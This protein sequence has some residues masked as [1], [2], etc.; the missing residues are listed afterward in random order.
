MSL[1]SM[2][3]PAQPAPLSTPLSAPLVGRFR[4]AA[5][6]GAS[7]NV[8]N[9]QLSRPPLWSRF[10]S[11]ILGW[12]L[13]RLYLLQRVL[14]RRFLQ[15][16][17]ESALPNELRMVLLREVRQSWASNLEGAG[18]SV[19]RQMFQLRSSHSNLQDSFSRGLLALSHADSM[20]QQ[21]MPRLRPL[22]D[23][24]DASPSWL[25]PV[26]VAVLTESIANIVRAES[27]EPPLVR[28][29]LRVLFLKIFEVMSKQGEAS[30]LKLPK[31]APAVPRE[32][33]STEVLWKWIDEYTVHLARPSHTR[34]G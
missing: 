21:V 26:C 2:Q 29:D 9:L 27:Q 7:N 17:T 13:R 25:E 15:T 28:V 12:P 20:W 3:H 23:R 31:W 16:L 33:A 11:A 4:G 5:E 24:V 10:Q 30:T 22:I 14:D 32:D 1:S 18:G 8:S 19:F 34:L 6:G